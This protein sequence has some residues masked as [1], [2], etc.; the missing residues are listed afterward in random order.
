M[1]KRTIK[2]HQKHCILPPAN[3]TS[4]EDWTNLEAGESAGGTLADGTDEMISSDE[5]I[6]GRPSKRSRTGTV[7]REIRPELVC[8]TLVPFCADYTVLFQSNEVVHEEHEVV[9]AGNP[10]A[11]IVPQEHPEEHFTEPENEED[12]EEPVNYCAVA[13]N[14]VDEIREQRNANELHIAHTFAANLHEQDGPPEE[15]EDVVVNSRIEHIK[16]AQQFIK[17]ISEATL[18]NGKLDAEVIERLRNPQERP[19]DI[20]E[21]DIRLSLDLF[22]ACENASQKTYSDVQESILRRSPNLNVL[23]Y[24]SVKNLVANI[25]GVVSISDDMCI[26]SCH[27]FTG[28][29]ADLQA[30][31]YCS[32]PRYDPDVRA[33]S[34]KLLPRKQE[35]TIPIGPQLQALRRSEQGSISMRYRDQKTQEILE[36]IET[37]ESAEDLVYDDIFSGTDY[38]DLAERLNLTSDDTT[39]LFSIDGAQLYQSKKSDTWIGIWI[40]ADYSPTLRY[41]KKCVLPA[42]VVPGPNKPKHMDSLLFRSF[43]HLSAIQRENNGAGLRMWDFVK[44]SLIFSRVIHILSTADAPGLTEIDGRVGH[45]GAHGCR[46]GCKIEGMHKPG[47]GHYYSVHLQPNGT[48]NQHD[49][50]LRNPIERESTE[51]YQENL[52]KVVNSR[53]QNDYERNRKYTGI[54]KPSII[55]GLYPDFTIPVPQCFSVDLMHL[56]SINLGELL[57]P[58]WRGTL[59]CESTDDIS[60]WDWATLT[61]A[62]WQN[63]GRLVA[64]ATI[65]FPSSFHR[66]PRNPAEKLSSGY[67]A[68]EYY[69]YLFGLGPAVFRTVLPGKYWRNLCKLVHGIRIIIQR[70]IT[71]KQLRE[72]HSYLVQFVEEYENIYYQRRMDRIHFCRPCIHTLLHTCPEAT[73]IGPGTYDTQYTMERSIGDLGQDIR[74][75]SN[76][77][78][79]LCQIAVRRSQINALKAMCPEIDR[80][81]HL[82]KY[83]HDNGDGY[84]FLTPRQ[85]NATRLQGAEKAIIE[86]E[87]QQSILRK[88]GRVRLPNGQIARSIFAE[89]RR[90]AAGNTRVTRNVKAKRFFFLYQFEH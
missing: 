69:L 61:G 80:D 71:G 1:S 14:D 68:T 87:L 6:Y 86:V 33:K 37:L 34:G 53:D 60:T 57:L 48:N 27:A 51:K 3:I 18:D 63:H 26:N 85:R 58:L 35:C 50:D 22:M 65:Y 24:G 46:I 59:K 9:G 36:L 25:S 73:R 82:S 47:S 42:F 89:G 67:K 31:Y 75:P 2:R 13:E 62:I 77:Y 38:L 5:D 83:S 45:H 78:G 72:A 12:L 15:L 44:K 74:Q 90:I 29:F 7:T 84:I 8:Y 81:I 40:I 21:P 64:D 20:S 4:Y 54:S 79:N 49:F 41:K 76:P 23:T 66:T 32:E 43:H 56:I 16:I 52:A 10:S 39:I 19:I 28:P 55:S 30:C 11:H 88:W 70:R 17:E